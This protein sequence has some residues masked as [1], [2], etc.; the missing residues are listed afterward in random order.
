MEKNNYQTQG[1]RASFK[2][3][4]SVA[5]SFPEKTA[6]FR[7]RAPTLAYPATFVFP[8]FPPGPAAPALKTEKKIKPCKKLFTLQG[9]MTLTLAEAYRSRTYLRPLSLTLVLKTNEYYFPR[10]SSFFII[11]IIQ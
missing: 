4:H 5:T 6:F 10:F 1:L 2:S 3:F 7:L 8:S 11:L 9:F